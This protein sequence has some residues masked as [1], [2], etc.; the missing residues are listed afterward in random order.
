M[1]RIQDFMK[2]MGEMK[3]S[4]IISG[5]SKSSRFVKWL[6][7]F[8]I[9]KTVITLLLVFFY[10]SSFFFVLNFI[11]FRKTGRHMPRC[12]ELALPL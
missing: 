2:E 7:A 5:K 11:Y 12:V 8:K 6:I 1:R 3:I 9:L 4:D 10:G